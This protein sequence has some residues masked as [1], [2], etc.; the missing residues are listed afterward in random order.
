MTA[1]VD[2]LT[3]FGLALGLMLLGRWGA[4]NAEILVPTSLD[5]HERERKKRV[6]ARGSLGC[7][8]LAVLFGLGG[9]LRPL[10]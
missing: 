1:L 9:L 4:R 2:T 5:E 7:Q 3:C 10:I 8:C 6:L